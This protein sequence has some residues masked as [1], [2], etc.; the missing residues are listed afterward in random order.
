[1]SATAPVRAWAFDATAQPELF[2][3]VRRRRA[4]GYLL[5]FVLVTI[6]WLVVS[7]LVFL[8]GIVTLS[9]GWL[10]L[11]A[12]WP[13]VALLYTGFT[14]GGRKAATPGM[15][16]MGLT[17]RLWY[18]AKPDFLV[19]VL[20]ALVFYATVSIATPLVLLVSLFSDKKRTLHD[21]VL[22]AVVVNDRAGVP[23]R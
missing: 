14:L 11:P 18:G 7:A 9:L 15:G 17:M 23:G 10:L 22:G 5:D 13:V 4:I 3:D 20:H 19:A 21:I 1:M 6:I 2:E 16:A 8:L 12:V